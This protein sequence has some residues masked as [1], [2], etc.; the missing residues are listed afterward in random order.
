MEAKNFTKVLHKAD[1]TKTINT[2][3]EFF[4]KSEVS[5]LFRDQF[6]K[7]FRFDH[8][9]DEINDHIEVQLMTNLFKENNKVTNSANEDLIISSIK[10][11]FLLGKDS[12][13]DDFFQFSLFM[14]KIFLIHLDMIFFR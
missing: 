9:T 2:P 12:D 1:S 3:Y 4:T 8:F 7:P 13:L 10:K 5:L 11:S 14:L 6:Y